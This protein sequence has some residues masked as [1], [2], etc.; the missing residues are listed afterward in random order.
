MIEQDQKTL[1]FLLIDSSAET[2]V[3]PMEG[4][5]SHEPVDQLAM[6]VILELFSNV[7]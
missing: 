1:T 4:F 6:I 3:R 5:H 2:R 7:C